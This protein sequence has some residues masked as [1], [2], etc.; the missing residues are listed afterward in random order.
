MLSFLFPKITRVEIVE[1]KIERKIGAKRGDSVAKKVS[2]T[3]LFEVITKPQIISCFQKNTT[4]IFVP[5]I[6]AIHLILK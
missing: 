5:P 6:Q 4:T 1:R 3:D 2:A